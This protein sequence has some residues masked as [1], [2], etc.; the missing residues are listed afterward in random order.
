MALS[1]ALQE[2]PYFGMLAVILLNA[3]VE[4]F[5]QSYAEMPSY[6]LFWCF[7]RLDPYF[8]LRTTVQASSSFA[9]LKLVT[10]TS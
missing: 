5:L 3:K 6:L 8:I 4:I 9:T 2:N 10:F 7:F 1:I